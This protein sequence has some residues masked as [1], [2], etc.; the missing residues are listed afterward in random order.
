MRDS[1]HTLNKMEKTTNRLDLLSKGRIKKKYRLPRKEKKRLKKFIYMDI[2]SKIPQRTK[3]LYK[4]L[5]GKD[6]PKLNQ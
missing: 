4:R 6:Y 3:T 5:F 2:G 1:L